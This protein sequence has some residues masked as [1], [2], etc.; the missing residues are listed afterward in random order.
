MASIYSELLRLKPIRTSSN[1]N[2]KWRTPAVIWFCSTNTSPCCDPS[3]G[4]MSPSNMWSAI[5]NEAYRY[6]F[7]GTEESE[8][9]FAPRS[10]H[11][12]NWI[13][14]FLGYVVRLCAPSHVNAA[15][16]SLSMITRASHQDKPETGARATNWWRQYLR[17]TDIPIL[18]SP[19]TII[20]VL[21]YI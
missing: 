16:S 7:H 10:F 21:R 18:I 17:A 15:L 20:L 5:S 3:R 1:V 14:L 2:N 11:Y 6:H 13:L 19:S 9:R 4:R 12:S 8:V